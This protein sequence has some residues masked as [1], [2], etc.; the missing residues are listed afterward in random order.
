VAER[1]RLDEHA[2]RLAIVSGCLTR[3]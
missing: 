1:A 3:A 2:R